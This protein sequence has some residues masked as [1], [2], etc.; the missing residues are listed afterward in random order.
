MVDHVLEEHHPYL[1]ECEL[2][3]IHSYFQTVVRLSVKSVGHT[4]V[5]CI[6]KIIHP[7][8]GL[9]V[10]SPFHIPFQANKY[11]CNI[12]R[13]FAYRNISET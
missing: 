5:N 6:T 10:V 4:N 8:W 12:L 13:C 9:V 3:Y 1:C 11:C 2:F 7:V